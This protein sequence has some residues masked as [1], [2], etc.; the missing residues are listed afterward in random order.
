MLEN[1]NIDIYDQKYS[2]HS[3]SKANRLRAFWVKEP[4]PIVGDL[5]DKLLEYWT[6]KRL[7]ENYLNTLQE[8]ALYNSCKTIASRLKGKEK[9]KEKNV[10]KQNNFIAQHSALLNTFEEFASLSSSSDKRRRGYLLEDLL[11][12]VFRL[13]DIP[14]EKSF[15][16]NEG[17]EQ[18][19]GAFTLDGW[20]YIVE[21]KWTEKLSDIRQLDS[22]YGKLNRSGKQTMGL[23]LSINGWSDNVVPLLKQ[24]QDKSIVLMDGYDL[25]CV[26]NEHINV[27][28]RALILKKLSHLNFDSEPFYSVSQFVD[29][30]KNS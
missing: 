6:E 8:E 28:L 19:D 5:I 29:E 21:C 10:C 18:I 25:R 1:M 26:L 27:N 7:I 23:F 17:G 13:Y 22:L 9:T 14:T 15:T 24:N 16:R 20:H 3:G 30:Q 4:N 2:Y 11:Q 12:K